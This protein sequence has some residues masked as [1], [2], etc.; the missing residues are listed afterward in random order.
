MVANTKFFRL[1]AE[2]FAKSW[3][4]QIVFQRSYASN[5]KTV[6]LYGGILKI[7]FCLTKESHVSIEDIKLSNDGA[8]DEIEVYFDWTL[9]RTIKTRNTSTN[10]QSWNFFTTNMPIAEIPNVKPGQHAIILNVSKSDMHGVEIDMINLFISDEDLEENVFK[11]Q[12]FCFDSVKHDHIAGL[13]FLP[14]GRIDQR[15]FSTT[16]TEIDNIVIPFYHDSATEYVVKATHPRYKAFLNHRESSFTNC[17][18]GSD[19]IWTYQNISFPLNHP[20]HTERVLLSVS[21]NEGKSALVFHFSLDG[22]YIGEMDSEM[23]STLRLYL[24]KTKHPIKVGFCYY[25]R[26]NSLIEATSQVFNSSI[27]YL[28]WDIPDFTWKEGNNNLLKLLFPEKIKLFIRK[29][30]LEKRKQK[31]DIPFCIYDNTD[32]T[33]EG[34]EMDFWWIKDH[35]MTVR[36]VDNDEV[37]TEAKY[38]RIYSRIPWESDKYSQVFVIYADGNIRLLPISP[39]G[40]DWIPF[41]SSLLVGYS[42]P[43]TKR[44]SAPISHIDID[45]KH[46]V[47]N[48]T[49]VNGDRSKLDLTVTFSE[50]ILFI[51]NLN[52]KEEKKKFPFLTFRS[53]WVK[54]GIADVDHL[55]VNGN[56]PRRILSDWKEL[57]GTS[58]VFYR[59]CLSSHN[60]M[61]PDIRVQLFSKFDNLFSSGFYNGNQYCCSVLGRFY[62]YMY[63]NRYCFKSF[64]NSFN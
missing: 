37:F 24:G 20:Y 43:N 58:F 44:P 35:K 52:F 34:V 39:P 57:F 53:M 19:L 28:S 41:G 17:T 13:D 61:S 63:M 5:H 8:E 36:V 30:E 60:T 9:K 54:D 12:A 22:P 25:T 42:D 2:D 1:E 6:H 64:V 31:P 27:E 10:G 51:K 7:E 55:S 16:C 26:N 46:K 45:P 23:G 29:V 38:V 59:K 33:I 50:T 56:A 14:N 21:H 62:T 47:L 49:Y 3:L 18:M 32:V 15:S 40:L 11:C 48:L 4:N